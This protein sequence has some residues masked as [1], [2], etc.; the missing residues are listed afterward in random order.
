M[1]HT[2][3]RKTKARSLT[4][5]YHIVSVCAKTF[6]IGKPSAITISSILKNS[7]ESEGMRQGLLKMTPVL[8]HNTGG[9]R[10]RFFI[11]TH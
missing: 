11:P 10:T 6:L 1:Y 8:G 4:R 3:Y 9:T 7:L 5:A 2:I